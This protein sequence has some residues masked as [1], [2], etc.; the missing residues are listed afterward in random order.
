MDR[1]SKATEDLIKAIHE[2]DSYKNYEVQKEKVR[3]MPDLKKKIDDFR[4]QSFLLQN[5][6]DADQLFDQVDVFGREYE[7][8]REIPLV[9][10]F[11]EAELDLIRTLQEINLRITESVNLE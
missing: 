3:R 2:S 8:F 6:V 1:I 5:N 7:E 11:L 4:Q 10:D 9:N